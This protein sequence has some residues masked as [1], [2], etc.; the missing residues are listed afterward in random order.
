MRQHGRCRNG[1]HRWFRS[2]RCWHI[3]GGEMPPGLSKENSD[4]AYIVDKYDKNSS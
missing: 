2:S 1:H 4:E 3:A